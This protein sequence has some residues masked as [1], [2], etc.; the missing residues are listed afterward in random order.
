MQTSC[1]CRRCSPTTS[2]CG[3]GT[4]FLACLGLAASCTMQTFM[5]LQ[6]VQSSHFQQVRCGWTGACYLA[7]LPQQTA[8]LLEG[9]E[10]NARTCALGAAEGSRGASVQFD[11]WL[12]NQPACRF[13]CRTFFGAGAAEGGAAWLLSLIAQQV[14]QSFH[15]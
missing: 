15:Y 8:C 14:A 11:A 7:D 13:C 4:F 6:G 5:C 2:R 9:R 10:G 3:Q 12:L 1:A